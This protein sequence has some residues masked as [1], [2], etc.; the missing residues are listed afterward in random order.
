MHEN[1]SLEQFIA[2]ERRKTNG[3]GIASFILGILGI[4]P[5]ILYFSAMFRDSQSPGT[6]WFFPWLCLIAPGINLAAIC[7]GGMALFETKKWDNSQKSY[8]LSIVGIVLGGLGI[9][10]TWR[11]YWMS[12]VGELGAAI[13]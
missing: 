12:Y 3:W 11:N 13:H 9:I 4:I 8:L 10:F 5:W 6:D 1:I 7:A 2:Q